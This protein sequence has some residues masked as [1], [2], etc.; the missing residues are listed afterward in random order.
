MERLALDV[1]RRDAAQRH[2]QHRRPVGAVE[3][4]RDPP[5]ELGHLLGRRAHQRDRRVVHVEVAALEALGHGVARAEVDHVERAERDDLRDAARGP[6]ASSRSG[7]GREDAADE[8]VG[9]LGRRDVEHAGQVAA[10]RQRLERLPAGAGGVE[11]EHLVAELLQP[12]ARARDAR[13]RDAEHRRADQRAL[14]AALGHRRRAPCPRSRRR[15]SPRICAEIWLIAGDVD[16]RVG[17]RDVDGADVR[18][19]VAR[20]DRR[21]DQLRHADRQVAHRLRRDRR[22]AR[23][24]DRGDAVQPALGVQPREHRGRAAPHR[25]DRRAAVAGAPRARRDRRPPARGD[26]LARHV[27]LDLRL[28]E[29]AG[30]RRAATSTPA[31]RDPVAQ[32]AVL[33]ALRVERADEDDGAPSARRSTPRKRRWRSGSAASSAAVVS[34][35]IRPA[36][37]TSWRSAIAVATARFC[38]T[39]R[40]A[41]PSRASAW[42]VSMSVSM[43]VGA[44]PSDGSSMIS[45]RG[46]AEQRAADR[47]HL[48]LAAGELHAAVPAALGQPREE[49]VHRVG[50]PAVAA[51]PRRGHP[52]VLV[53]RQRLEQPPPLRARSRSRRRRSCRTRGRPA[54]AR[55]T[56]SSRSGRPGGICMI[57]LQSVVLPIPLRPISATGS[58]P[59]SK[60]TPWSTCARP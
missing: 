21:D 14:A 37:I 31:S 48:L 5:P 45:S 3:L 42:N 60:L 23:A 9:Q 4:A 34:A 13:R 56:G 28:A 46:F 2:E 41:R 11:D 57:A 10:G 12:L 53:D 49:L 26:L 58:E 20:G 36:T 16:D 32:E 54:R 15:R 50:R 39:T 8:F 1:D 7:P 38:S 47:E 40:I 19:R 29:H 43:I 18:A 22:V 17:H 24:A 59:I 25:V 35:K 55:R 30:S 52:Q 6:T 27:G 33:D 51:S 44:S